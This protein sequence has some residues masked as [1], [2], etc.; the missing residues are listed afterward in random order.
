MFHACNM[1]GAVTL[2]PSIRREWIE[3]RCQIARCEDLVSPSIRREWI[4]IGCCS[5]PFA[6]RSVSLHTEGVD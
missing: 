2:S 5:C 4:E 6:L 1:D 3:I